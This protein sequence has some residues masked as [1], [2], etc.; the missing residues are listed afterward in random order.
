MRLRFTGGHADRPA[1]D[2]P[3]IAPLPAAAAPAAT[4]AAT[5]TTPALT[6]LTLIALGRRGERAAGGFARRLAVGAHCEVRFAGERLG[7]V[8]D[9]CRAGLLR[10]LGLALL[11][12]R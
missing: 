6:G 4:A 10:T 11:G 8:L 9:G 1:A 12:L 2:G 5:A 3:A 7:R